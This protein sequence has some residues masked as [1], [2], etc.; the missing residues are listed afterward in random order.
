MDEDRVGRWDSVVDGWMSRPVFDVAA[1][2]GVVALHVALVRWSP[3]PELLEGVPLASRLSLY[4]A[5]AFVVSLTGTF[6]SLGV[7]QY[8]S[9]KGYR[10]RL[11]KEHHAAHLTT[12]WRAILLG[13]IGAAILILV[14]WVFDAR[15]PGPHIGSWIYE[16]G[17]LLAVLRLVRLVVLLGAIIDVIVADEHDPIGDGSDM[18]WNPKLFERRREDHP[19]G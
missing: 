18:Q 9:G 13:S 5:T 4:T 15:T 14:A 11:L 19:V 6:A 2:G 7:G 1:A 10:M 17:I 12:T 16:A 3:V 8:L